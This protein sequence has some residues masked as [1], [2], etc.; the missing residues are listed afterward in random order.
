MAA[1]G[2]SRRTVS[3]TLMTVRAVLAR[4]MRQG[5][6]IRNVAEGV[7]AHGA[8]GQSREPLTPEEVAAV[9]GQARRH[10]LA[11]A[12]S[13]TLAGMRRSE[14]LGLRWQDL[15][16][17]AHDQA[18]LTI[19][20]GRIGEDQTLTAPKTRRGART[21]PLTPDMAAGLRAWRSHLAE[22]LGIIA[23]GPDAFVVV[24]EAGRPIRPEWYS[25]E[26]VRL[27]QAAGVCKR[28]RLHEARHT[29]VT[30]M[31]VRGVAVDASFD[32]LCDCCPVWGL[33]SGS[34]GLRPGLAV[35]HA[36]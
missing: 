14:V 8:D 34:G 35:R 13:M 24:D 7:K 16:L 30:M 2:L 1:R 19:R 21:L 31:Q 5:A 9:A 15:T 18:T 28:V 20:H 17:S 36:G 23:V 33:G 32:G 26:W 25:D 6:A 12:W 4:A 11:S 22:T 27:C 3:L 29:S 10:R